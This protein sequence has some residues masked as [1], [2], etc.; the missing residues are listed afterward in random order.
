MREQVCCVRIITHEGEKFVPIP[1][2]QV[3]EIVLLRN[4]EGVV[5]IDSG[6]SVIPGG[7]YTSTYTGR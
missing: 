3:G 1:V 2:M 5:N 6:S 4:G 7:E